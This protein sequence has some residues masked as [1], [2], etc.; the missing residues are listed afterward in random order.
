MLPASESADHTGD[1]RYVD[2][3]LRLMTESLKGRGIAAE[4][5]EWKL[6]GGGRMLRTEAPGLPDI[7]QRNVAAAETLLETMGCP[8][9]A[10]DVGGANHR[11]IV[12]DL[13]TGS[14]WSRRAPP[15]PL[16]GRP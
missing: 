2:A 16:G 10:R 9:V 6:F 14:V 11:E 5:C 4:D 8:P 7:G 3:A 13:R 12:F 15:V 1:P